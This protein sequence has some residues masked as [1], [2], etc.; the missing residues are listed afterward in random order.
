MAIRVAAA[1]IERGTSVLVTRRLEGTHLE[2]LWE[3]PG[4]KCEP[5]ESMH[6]CLVREI[7]EELALEIVPGG[8]LLVT[9]HE[10]PGKT[11]EL[12]FIACTAAGEPAPQQGQQMLW[13]ER[14]RLGTL[15]FPEADAELIASL[16]RR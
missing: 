15:A 12:H 16:M 2:G 4:G 5:G 9:R 11:V 13:I 7:A 1:V 14:A 8:T 10:Y 6:E 3:F